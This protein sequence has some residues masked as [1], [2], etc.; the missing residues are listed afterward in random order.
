M[1]AWQITGVGAPR[2]VLAATE[3]DAPEPGPGELRVAVRAAAVGMPDAFLCRGSYAYRPPLPCIAGQEV[4]GMV[5]A[6]GPG[7]TTSVGT[8]RMGVTNFF[9]GRGGF[10][11]HTIVRE[12][13]A[14]RVPDAMSDAEAAGF[15][16]AYSTAWVGLVRRAGITPGDRLLVLGAAGGSGAAAV[17]LGRALGAEV[18]AV[19]GGAEKVALCRDLGAHAVVDRTTSSVVDAVQECT[20]GRG[21]DLVY[22]PVGGDAA[23]ATVGCLARDG[24]LLAVGF[25]SGRWVQPDVHRMV[26]R[27][28]SVV[29]VYAGGY[30]RAENEVDHEALLARWERGELRGTGPT[31]LP[32]DALPDAVARVD[33]G[34][35]VG[36]IVV[37]GPG[38]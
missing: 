26:R 4:C 2:D 10:A 31:V 28:A 18:I 36:K 22:D 9:D 38:D 17:T 33:E 27:N 14:F 15:R 35:S 20:G 29:G 16:I 37:R 24:R 32:F 8:R 11:G 7:T 13:S 19:A 30:T 1:H 34:R 21:V 3:L 25:A 6:A 23:D 5:D 12:E